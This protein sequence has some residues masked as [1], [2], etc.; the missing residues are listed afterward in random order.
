M[1]MCITS[2]S[3]HYCI[4][5]LTEDLCGREMKELEIIVRRATPRVD[6]LI[7]YWIML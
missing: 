7:L 2:M 5:L 6:S 1:Y 3:I 4:W